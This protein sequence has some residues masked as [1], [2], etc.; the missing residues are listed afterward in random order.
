MALGVGMSRSFSHKRQKPAKFAELGPVGAEWAAMRAAA[1]P[2][3]LFRKWYR[4]A[5]AAGTR[6]PEAMALATATRAGRPSVRMV[7][8]RGFSGGGFVFFTNFNSRKA[9]ELMAETT[10]GEVPAEEE[11][12]EEAASEPEPK[13]EKVPKPE[14]A[15][16]PKKG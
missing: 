3:A 14:P 5:V 4:D 6:L 10:A 9:V 16:K 12:G 2:M 11:E 7:L 8:Q 15:K 1:D 13:A